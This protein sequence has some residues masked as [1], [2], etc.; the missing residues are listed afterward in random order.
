VASWLAQVAA[1]LVTIVANAIGATNRV[2]P[3]LIAP[4]NPVPA[5][6]NCDT[7]LSVSANRCA[8]RALSCAWP[9]VSATRTMPKRATRTCDG[10]LSGVGV[11]A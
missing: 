2:A 3:W 1:K 7:R 11:D 5:P 10:W 8:V 4:T 9:H 6:F